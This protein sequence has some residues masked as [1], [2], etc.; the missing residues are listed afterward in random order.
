MSYRTV[1]QHLPRRLRRYILHFE[2]AID[3]AVDAFARDLREG[4]TVLDAGAGECTFKDRFRHQRY[5]AIDSGIGDAG[6]N[7]SGL[8]A[9]A[10]LIGSVDG[11]PR[12]LSS[13][14]KKY[15]RSTGYGIKRAG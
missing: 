11:L 15:L 4:A 8:D 10:D 9:I 13:R 6:W 12:D 1:Q 14:T 5:L 7:Y 3:D 2:A